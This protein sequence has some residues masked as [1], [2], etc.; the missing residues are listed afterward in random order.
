M[1]KIKQLIPKSPKPPK[2]KAYAFADSQEAT[3]WKP[4]VKKKE[5]V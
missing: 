2:Q 1:P 5:K 3:I 4:P